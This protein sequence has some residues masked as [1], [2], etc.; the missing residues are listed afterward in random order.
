MTE[1]RG[2]L[3]DGMTQGDLDDGDFA[4][5][6]D[7]YKAGNESKTDGRK[8]PYKIHGTVNERGWRAAWTRVHQMTAADFAG[9]PSQ[10]ATIAKLLRDKPAAVNVAPRAAHRGGIEIRNSADTWHGADL[11]IRAVEG[12]GM[13]FEGYAAVFNRDSEPIAQGGATFIERIRPGAFKK[14][15]SERGANIRMFLNHNA[16]NVLATTR[17]KTLSLAEDDTG[18][19]VTA[20]LPETQAGKDLSTLIQRGDVDSMSFGFSATRDKWDEG[21]TQRELI[22]VRL[23][24]VSPVTGWPAYV[25][26]SAAVRHLAEIVDAEAN[27]LAEA[28]HSWLSADDPLTDADYRMLFDALNKRRG[29]RDLVIPPSILKAR[30]EAAEFMLSPQ[31]RSLSDLAAFLLADESALQAAINKLANGEPLL[32]Q[33]ADL[34]EAAIEHLEPPDADEDDMGD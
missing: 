27:D 6:S 2:W 11:E 29:A 4:W 34:L 10:D 15:L 13:T 5:L 28:V 33:E 24:E 3:P 17:A 30:A 22:E 9:G 26:T 31:D 21:Y 25:D 12:D 23:H 32:Q 19:K 18:L 8:L 16:D 7:A 14:S 1:D 20:K